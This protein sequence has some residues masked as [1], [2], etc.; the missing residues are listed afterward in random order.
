[1]NRIIEKYKLKPDVT[2]STLKKYNFRNSKCRIDLYNGLIYLIITVE[3]DD[4]DEEEKLNW[5]TFQVVNDDCNTLYVPYY[6][7]LLGANELV[8]KLDKKIDKIFS[9][10]ND[11]FELDEPIQKKRSKE[12]R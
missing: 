7:R 10:M 1:M 2:Y 3:L 8:E 5:W 4:S 6:N 9:K 12:K 11:V